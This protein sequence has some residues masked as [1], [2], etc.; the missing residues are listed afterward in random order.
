MSQVVC[1]VVFIVFSLEYEQIRT[2]VSCVIKVLFITIS[3]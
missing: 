3:L 2:L 1:K